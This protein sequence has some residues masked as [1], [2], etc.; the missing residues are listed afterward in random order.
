MPINDK[1]KQLYDA[2]KEDGGDVGSEQEFSDWFFAKGDEGY[3]NRKYVYDTFKEA[4]ADIGENYEEFRDWLGLHAVKH[5]PSVE[6][7]YSEGS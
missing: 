7:M 2:L 5:Q 6:E 4:G 1:V 3:Q